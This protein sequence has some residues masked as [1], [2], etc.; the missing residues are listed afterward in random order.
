[1][2]LPQLVGWAQKV[3]AR[4]YSL[5]GYPVLGKGVLVERVRELS[6]VEQGS[7]KTQGRGDGD[8]VGPSWDGA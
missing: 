4:Q 6:R 1:M 8:V 2:V 3:V 5:S 7:K